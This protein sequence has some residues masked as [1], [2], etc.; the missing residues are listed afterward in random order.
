VNSQDIRGPIDVTKEQ[1]NSLWKA[2]KKEIRHVAAASALP[3][4][5]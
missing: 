5:V 3:N 4:V 1:W 2:G